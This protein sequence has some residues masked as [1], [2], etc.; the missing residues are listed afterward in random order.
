[1]A[2]RAGE[3]LVDPMGHLAR[4]G[5]IA[6]EVTGRA[7]GREGAHSCVHDLDPGSEGLHRGHHRLE[8]SGPAIRIVGT[9]QLRT[10]D[11]EGTNRCCH[12]FSPR[13]VALSEW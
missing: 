8:G 2:A 1:L 13:F 4:Q 11:N 7:P 3:H 9:S 6:P 5:L 12:D 10:D